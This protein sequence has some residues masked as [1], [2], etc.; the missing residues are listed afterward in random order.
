MVSSQLI[1][2][3]KKCSICFT[4]LVRFCFQ[5]SDL[6]TL[7][8]GSLVC[9]LLKDYDN[10]EDVNKQLDRMYNMTHKL[11]LFWLNISFLV[12]GCRGYNIGLRI[13]EDFLAKTAIPRCL[14][15][16]D[17]SERIQ[18]AF[19]LY[20][21]ITPTIANWS[22]ANDEFSLVLDNNPLAEFAELPDHLINLRYSNILPGIIRGALEMVNNM[23]CFTNKIKQS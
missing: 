8:Y 17:V 4:L 11:Q 19:R 13:V 22:Q 5:S 9:Q 3:L 23:S 12:I 20:L 18:S 6:F 1:R 16:K 21:G 10:P 7:T 14:D 15:F 2:V